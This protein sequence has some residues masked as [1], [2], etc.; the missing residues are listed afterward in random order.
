MSSDGAVRTRQIGAT[1]HHTCA[2]LAWVLLVL[3]LTPSGGAG[4]HGMEGARAL[5]PELAYKIVVLA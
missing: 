2:W 4:L 3:V 1:L 5:G